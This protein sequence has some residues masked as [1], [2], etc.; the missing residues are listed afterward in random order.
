MVGE[1]IAAAGHDWLLIG[2]LESRSQTHAKQFYEF[3]AQTKR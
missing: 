3:T 1:F 2:T